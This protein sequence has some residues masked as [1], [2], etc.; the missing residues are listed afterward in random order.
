MPKPVPVSF[1]QFVDSIAASDQAR[2][3]ADPVRIAGIPGLVQKEENSGNRALILDRVE[4]YHGR[5]VANLF[6]SED[7]ILLSVG[8]QDRAAFFNEID[9]AIERPRPLNYTRDDC[10]EFERHAGPGLSSARLPPIVH[11]ELDST[12]YITSGVVVARN[13]STGLHHLCFIRL[14]IID[15]RTLSFNATTPR[16]REICRLTVGAGLP[17]DVLVL[18]GAPP[19]VL[20]SGAL[21]FPDGVDELE[22]VQ[23]WAGD[24]LEF[25]RRR[26]P[27]PRT[28]EIALIGQ[29]IPEYRQEGP[30]GDSFGT[31]STRRNPICKIREV[32]TQKQTPLYHMLLGGV[33]TEHVE[34]LV[35]K[36][37]HELE[38]QLARR[39][40]LVDYA[41]P[42]FGGGRLCILKVLPGL[43]VKPWLNDLFRIPLI[44]TVVLVDTDIDMASE[45]DILWAITRRTDGESSFEFGC[46][47]SG[48]TKANKVVIDARAAN[49]GD[50]ND[51]RIA[52]PA[53]LSAP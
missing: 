24:G 9:A 19:K 27:I 30:F 52:A 49:P 42:V 3:I 26:L 10:P 6:G 38:H 23:G 12:P 48:S 22:V 16:I 8:T 14:A 18:I 13:P 46:D 15:D 33:S 20:L 51:R 21:H 2:S 40:G 7:R 43:D 28:T 50:W 31:Y 17:L 45:R 29:V 5:L 1:R 39:D 37:R 41:L 47:G 36:A 4:G 25:V 53:P 44:R 35:L 32:W 34:L 11:S